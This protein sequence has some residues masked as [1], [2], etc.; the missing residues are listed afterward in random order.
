MDG[1]LSY[2]EAVARK[3]G[4][5][6]IFSSLRCLHC[7]QEGTIPLNCGKHKLCMSCLKK[8]CGNYGL[9]KMDTCPAAECTDP[10]S[11]PP[12]WIYVDNS[13]IWIGAKR[14]A[15]K[16][17]GFQSYKDHRVRINIGNLTDVVAKSRDVKTGTLY[18]SEPPQIDSVWDKIRE[19]KHWTVKTK[20]KSYLTHKEKEVD[21]QLLVDVT[22]VA[23]TTPVSERG[24][25]VLITG[26][27][28][29][30]PAVEKIMEYDGWKV[31]IYMWQDSLSSRLQKLSKTNENVICEPLD[32]HMMDVVFTNNKFPA[33]QYAIPKECSAVLT[34][35]PGCFPKRVIDSEWWKKLESIAQWPVQYLWIIKDDKETDDM[36]LVFSHTGEK[37]KY[38]VSDLVQVV[39]DDCASD[40]EPLLAHVQKAETYIDYAKRLRNFE[41]AVM[42]YGR[43]KIADIGSVSNYVLRKTKGSSHVV[44]SPAF[45]REVHVVDTN[46]TSLNASDPSDKFKSV[47]PTKVGGKPKECYLGKNCI[48]G[49]KCEFP[50][51]ASDKIFFEANGGKGMPNRKT[52]VCRKY[53]SCHK[54]PS[55]CN[56]AHGD[57]DGW[58]LICRQHGHFMKACPRRDEWTE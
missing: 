23:C 5:A 42:K 27:A 54:N 25:I 52:R 14:L 37:V 40:A 32:N 55:M 17:K 18:G 9:E 19:H 12:I 34:M 28:D 56:Y 8:N 4:H 3:P 26:D 45:R 44:K 58:C 16:V 2:A 1:A 20:K 39:S 11:A 51:S 30:C 15:S 6:R 50:H 29:M 35:E 53:P 33:T 7:P 21:A 49:Q 24:T 22:E 13:N 48:L 47:P 38:N 10:G 43:F 36:L 57:R 41:A 31:E 46:P